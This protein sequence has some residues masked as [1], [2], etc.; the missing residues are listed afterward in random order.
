LEGALGSLRKG[1]KET[2]VGKGLLEAMHI[3]RGK[4]KSKT[5][6]CDEAKVMMGGNVCPC[7][8]LHPDD[9]TGWEV[10][11]CGWSWE[12][13]SVWGLKMVGGAVKE[14]EGGNVTVYREDFSKEIGGVDEAGEYKDGSPSP[15]TSGDACRST[16]T[17]SGEPKKSQ[18]QS[19]IRC[20]QTEGEGTV[21]GGQG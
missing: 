9:W 7:R 3:V 16:W 6:E 4:M 1:G 13:G 11:L 21:E 18:D 2:G 19:H 10:M 14:G 8:A 5:E 17:S 12:G 20:R 15:S